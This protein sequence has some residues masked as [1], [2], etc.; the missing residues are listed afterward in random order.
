M[1]PEQVG[2]VFMV[3]YCVP[4]FFHTFYGFKKVK[5]ITLC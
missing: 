1:K 3:L 5:E 4:G 2:L